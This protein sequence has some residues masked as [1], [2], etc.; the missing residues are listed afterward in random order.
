MGGKSKPGVEK[1][2]RARNAER[3]RAYHKAWSARNSEKRRAAR[4]RWIAKNR[5]YDLATRNARA[6]ARYKKNPAK[7]RALSKRN[8][9]ER[10]ANPVTAKQ[11]KERK[12]RHRKQTIDE[13]RLSYARE[14]LRI[15]GS[16]P[17]TLILLQQAQLKLHRS[18]KG[19]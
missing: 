12:R 3:L 2:W 18:L 9:L 7:Q 11:D 13:I 10:A 16:I 15:K 8:A 4:K 6:K 14:S 5:E 19:K 1:A 17:H